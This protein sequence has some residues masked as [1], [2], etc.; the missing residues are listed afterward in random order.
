MSQTE[1]DGAIVRLSNSAHARLVSS[2]L[3]HLPLPAHCSDIRPQEDNA[4]PTLPLLHLCHLAAACAETMKGFTIAI[5]SLP[6]HLL[7]VG[8]IT[9]PWQTLASS[10]SANPVL[11]LT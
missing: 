2:N 7:L 8:I 9:V 6:S 10:N 3:N 1:T 11:D 5:A 4:T